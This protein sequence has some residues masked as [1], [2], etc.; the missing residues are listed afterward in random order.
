MGENLWIRSHA[1]YT[2]MSKKG[3]RCQAPM[4]SEVGAGEKLRYQ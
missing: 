3:G 1:T 2:Q 4:G